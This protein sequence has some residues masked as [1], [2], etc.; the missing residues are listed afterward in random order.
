MIFTA[1]PEH[2][3][4]SHLSEPKCCSDKPG[5]LSLTEQ[6]DTLAQVK[7]EII[8]GKSQEVYDLTGTF[9]EAFFLPIHTEINNIL[10]TK[11]RLLEGA[12]TPQRFVSY[13]EH[14]A[15]ERA[16]WQL[17]KMGKDVSQ[18]HVSA[19]PS[20]FHFDVRRGYQTV[21]DRYEASSA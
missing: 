14:Y 10:K 8:K 11:V 20:E 18:M 4:A 3:S 16:Y 21:L 7:E 9:Y 6:L 2:R 15:G 1:A 17:A 13:F 5:H 19:Y 12:S